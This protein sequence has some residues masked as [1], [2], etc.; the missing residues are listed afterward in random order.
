MTYLTDYLDPVTTVL[1][2]AVGF[3][4]KTAFAGND[5]VK[6]LLP[7]IVGAIGVIVICWANG[8]IAPLYI[9]KGLISGLASSGMYDAFDNWIKKRGDEDEKDG[10]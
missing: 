9:T 2:L 3:I 1:C 8:S 10:D 4:V 6:K 7:C 5:I